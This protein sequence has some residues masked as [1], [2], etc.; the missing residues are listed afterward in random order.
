MAPTTLPWYNQAS[1]DFLESNKPLL[2]NYNIFEYGLGYSTIYYSHFVKSITGVETRMEWHNL[3]NASLPK[4]QNENLRL[5]LQLISPN[6]VH[7]FADSIEELF[8]CYKF[9]KSFIIID[10]NQ[11]AKCLEKSTAFALQNQGLNVVIMLDNSERLNLQAP[12][13]GAKNLGFFT[14]TFSSARPSDGLVSHSTFFCLNEKF[15]Q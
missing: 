9:D 6:L 12:I 3:V 8:F 1:I 4:K 7:N 2:C 13:E 10:S 15:F 11:R 5:N 14:K